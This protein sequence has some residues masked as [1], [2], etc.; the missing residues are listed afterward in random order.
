MLFFIT[1]ISLIKIS[2]ILYYF[3]IFLIEKL[4]TQYK[5]MQVTFLTIE[6]FKMIFFFFK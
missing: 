5:L 1:C 3:I 6:Y 2:I 4:K